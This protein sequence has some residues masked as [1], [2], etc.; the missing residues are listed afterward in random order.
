[1]GIFGAGPMTPYAEALER[2]LALLR[3]CDSAE[4]AVLSELN[5]RHT[6]NGR[7]DLVPAHVIRGVWSD[8][9]RAASPY[10]WT[11]AMCVLLEAAAPGIGGWRLEEAAFPSFAGFCLFARP[12]RLD[13]FVA[14]DGFGGDMVAFSWHPVIDERTDAPTVTFV[15]YDHE[16]GFLLGT[17]VTII[18][19]PV[20]QRLEDT[21]AVGLSRD[22]PRYRGRFEQKLQYI[23]AALALMGQ[24]L[25]AVRAE[26]VD[27]SARRRL[28]RAGWEHEPVVRVVELRRRATEPHDHEVV[29][30]EWSCRWLVRGHWRQQWC[31]AAREHRPIWITPYVK[32]PE[33]KPL[34]PPRATVFAVVR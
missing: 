11:P 6:T 27:R 2:Q 8:A 25:V 12:L 23:A 1:V 34:K 20:G 31:P 26:S 13:P 14:Q 21:I 28:E 4:A 17:P 5:A 16:P 7:G 9:L 32:G 29:S 30:V 18:G 24:T 19:W 22:P 15:V 33:M 3:W 10:Y